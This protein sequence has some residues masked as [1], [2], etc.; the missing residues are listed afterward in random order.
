MAA[1]GRLRFDIV[2]TGLNIT[3]VGGFEV[4]RAFREVDPDA[5]I[6]YIPGCPPKP[7]AMIAG[8]AKALQDL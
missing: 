7:E 5:I 8:L 1:A 3:P 2:L 4:L 6:L